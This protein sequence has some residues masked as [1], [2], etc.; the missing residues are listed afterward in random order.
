MIVELA[1]G[2]FL[3]FEN[4]LI[5]CIFGFQGRNKLLTG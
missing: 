3:D 2:N 1:A 5:M 4:I